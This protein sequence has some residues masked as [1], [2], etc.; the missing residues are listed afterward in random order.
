MQLLEQERLRRLDALCE[1]CLKSKDMLCQGVRLYF[2]EVNN[3]YYGK[4]TRLMETE[5][6]KNRLVRRMKSFIPSSIF[7]KLDSKPTDDSQVAVSKD[8]KGRWVFGDVIVP[9]LCYEKPSVSLQHL[10]F[11]WMYAMIEDG[12]QPR[13]VYTPAFMQFY[14]KPLDKILVDMVN[15][16]DWLV[17][18]RL[19]LVIGMDAKQE[20]L[21]NAIQYRVSQGLPTLITL[22]ENP[23]PRTQSDKDFYEEVMLW[24]NLP[25]K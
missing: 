23:D 5:V 9:K 22:G 1:V 25:L 14:N 11:Q 3:F 15:Y 12:Y 7:E 17:V 8:T 19:D 16:C 20:Y 24:H 6:D 10:I 13:F 18:D 2:D 4:C 21:R